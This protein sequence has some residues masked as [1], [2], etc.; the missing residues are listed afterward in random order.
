M[1]LIL[2]VCTLVLQEDKRAEADR[3]ERK[4]AQATLEKDRERWLAEA[5]ALRADAFAEEGDF[6]SA[7]D[8][9]LKARAFGWTGPM[10]TS[11]SSG[12]GRTLQ[13]EDHP[14]GVPKPIRPKERT[15][16][17]RAVMAPYGGTR[18]GG[19]HSLIHLP[20]LEQADV[21]PRDTWHAAAKVDLSVVRFSDSTGGGTSEWKT[22]TISEI[23]EAD[24]AILDWLQVGLRVTMGEVFESGDDLVL[25]ENN[26]QIVPEGDRSFAIESIIVRGKAAFPNNVLDFGILVEVK[27]PTSDEENFLTAD[28]FDL[29]FSGIVTKRFGDWAL[30]ANFGMTLPI[31][32]TEFFRDR[33]D[34]STLPD[35]NDVSS[36]IH[37]GVGVTWRI[38]PEFMLGFQVE[39]NSAVFQEVSVLDD[40]QLTATLHGRYKLA[41]DAF[42]SAALGTGFGDLSPDFTFSFSF[43]FVF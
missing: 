43:D 21:Y 5:W 33:S 28:T 35:T 2:V 14:L 41:E 17:D 42:F 4:A 1:E 18:N 22:V 20:P 26:I 23:F 32:E 3:L 13:D 37:F 29:A 19:S 15:L 40:A 30:H 16:W 36:V 31:G 6:D 8:A 39:G 9:W 11:R 24:Y 7:R 27:I 38:W 12:E 34:F 25:F 10:P